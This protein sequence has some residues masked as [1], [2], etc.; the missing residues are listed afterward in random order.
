MLKK[1]T[2]EDAIRCVKRK[3]VQNYTAFEDVVMVEELLK[4]EEKK[5]RA[6]LI[7]SKEKIIIIEL[8]CNEAAQD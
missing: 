4:V 6:I 5:N 2:F 8:I 3:A 7:I 1:H